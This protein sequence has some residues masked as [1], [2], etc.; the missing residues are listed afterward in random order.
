M[1]TPEFATY[2]V[3]TSAPRG[4]RSKTYE[5]FVVVA[6]NEAHAK[7]TALLDAHVD[8]IVKSVEIVHVCTCVHRG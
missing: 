3:K 2:I 6:R 8:A 7:L 5:T 4:P 1:N